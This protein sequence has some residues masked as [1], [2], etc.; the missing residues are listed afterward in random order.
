MYLIFL[1]GYDSCVKE[2]EKEPSVEDVLEFIDEYDIDEAQ[3]DDIKIY[4]L[5]GVFV[6]PSDKGRID[7]VSSK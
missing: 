5:N 4:K 1:D 7:K 3:R 6:P 2:L